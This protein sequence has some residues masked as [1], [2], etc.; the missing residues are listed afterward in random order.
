MLTNAPPVEPLNMRPMH[1][2]QYDSANTTENQNN[3][4]KKEV[5]NQNLK[6]RI[7]LKTYN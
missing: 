6:F 3:L 1:N 2:T 5:K 7:F 4:K